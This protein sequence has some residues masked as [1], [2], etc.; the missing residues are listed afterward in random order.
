M[1]ARTKSKIA[2]FAGPSFQDGSKPP[3]VAV[4]AGAETGRSGPKSVARSANVESR[5]RR[6][7]P[8]EGAIGLM[9]TPTS[10]LIAG[11]RV[12]QLFH[13]LLDR[14]AARL[15]ARR[16]L[17]K[18]LEV[19]RHERLRWDQHE[20]V[21]DEPP[22]VVA[23]LV[24]AP[25]KWIRTQVEQPGQ[26]QLHQRLCPDIEAMRPLLQEHGLPL[27]VAQASEV[28]VVGPVEELADLVR[29]PASE[30][31]TLVVAVEM[32]FEGLAGGIVALQELVLDV[33]L[34]G[35]SDQRRRP[36]LGGEDVVDLDARRHQAGPAYHRGHAIAA[37]PVGVLLAA[38]RRRAAVGPGERLGAVV[39]GVDHDRIVG[40]AEIVELLQELA[41][42]PVMLHHPVRIDAE[43]G[44]SLRRWLEMGPNVHAGRIEPDEERL[45]VADGAVDEFHRGLQELLVDCLHAFLGERASVVA[46]LLA[47]GAEAWIVARRVGGG[48]DALENAARTEL[49]PKV[50]ILGIVG[51]LGLLL[52]VQV[53]E[54]AEEYVEAVHGRQEFV[55]VAEM[56]LAKLSGRVALRLEQ[57]GN[58]RVLL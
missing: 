8:E 48:R 36:V 34:A 15:L 52:G 16:E 25:L 11:R 26:A 33:W 37:L 28:A 19:L 13:G 58:R 1:V 51:I 12:P 22:H 5:T 56:V 17:L 43:P 18:A 35:G 14:E 44:L 31:I 50:G 20:G 30:L 42:L 55:A 23:R 3:A 47:P 32:N 53:I 29:P 10:G 45:A 39:G 40:D 4:C 21:L 38:E 9:F 6:F 57:I 24:L 27:L 49:R 41:D 2:C 7:I 46:F 54:V